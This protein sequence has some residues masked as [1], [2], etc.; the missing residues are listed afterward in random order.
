MQDFINWCNSNQG[1]AS[2]DK[3]LIIEITGYTR[4]RVFMLKKY[5]EIFK[6]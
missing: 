6:A 3:G 4:N 5:F 1:F 2:V